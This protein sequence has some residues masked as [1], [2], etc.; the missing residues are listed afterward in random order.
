MPSGAR[1]L[2]FLV[3][4]TENANTPVEDRLSASVRDSSHIKIPPATS[5]DKNPLG[6]TLGWCLVS[7]FAGS[8]SSL[9]VFY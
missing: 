3:E 8:F 5:K 2:F 7:A 6:I 4:N 9:L 1:V